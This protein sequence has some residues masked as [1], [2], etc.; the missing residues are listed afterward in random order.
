MTRSTKTWV[1][2]ILGSLAPV[3]MA[4]GDPTV[5]GFQV[6]VYAWI[7]NTADLTFGTDGSLYVGDSTAAGIQV[8]VRRIPPGGGLVANYGDSTFAD[9]DTVLFD[10]VGNISGV[11]GSVLVA[12]QNSDGGYVKAI[13]PSGLVEQVFGPGSFFL[14]PGNMSFDSAGRFVMSD[15]H[16]TKRNVLVSTGG[17]LSVLFSMNAFEV[18]PN[19]TAI[20]QEDRIFVGSSDGAIRV[21]DSQGNLL[22]AAFVTGLSG[23]PKLA[24][25]Q[26]G[27]WGTDLYTIDG[28]NLLNVDSTG[29]VT[30]IGTGF[31]DVLRME[32]GPDGALYISER[33]IPDSETDRIL[34]VA[35]AC[36]AD[37]DGDNIVGIGD[38]LLV[39]AQWGPCPPDCLGDVDGDG[40]VGINDFLLVLAE[41][42]PCP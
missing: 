23:S 30:A 26:G 18:A 22:N 20:D 14:N 21:F 38:F 8:F 7:D 36:H 27:Q 35:P 31:A 32:F 39:L 12:G 4:S 11:P 42:G 6:D 29:N 34:R 41:W 15:I 37:T 5:P 10:A 33:N 17:P 25:G 28:P 40:L 24:F 9:P 16:P 2:S 19:D 13:R 1:L 3:Y